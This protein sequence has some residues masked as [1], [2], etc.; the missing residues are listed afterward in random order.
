M[1]IEASEIITSLSLSLQ[2]HL[3]SLHNQN[4]ND[5]QSIIARI[6]ERVIVL[7]ATVSH[8]EARLATIEANQ[9]RTV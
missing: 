3:T 5:M 2:Q 7:Q 9:E 4:T 6:E 1:S 8:I